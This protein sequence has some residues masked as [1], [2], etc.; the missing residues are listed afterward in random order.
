MEG[1]TEVQENVGAAL[2]LRD[3][4]LESREWEDVARL[5]AKRGATL[6][7]A[8]ER[9]K[10]RVE[11]DP[12]N[13]T[14]HSDGIF[15][16]RQLIWWA[17]AV[18]MRAVGVTNHD[19]IAP[20]I[21]D[22][23]DEASRLGVRFVPGLEYTIHR[24]GG[25]TWRGL[26]VG[27]HFFPPEKF[28][29]FVRSEAGGRFCRRFEEA[30]RLKSDQAWAALKAVNERFMAPRGLAPIKRGELWDNSGRTDPVCASVLTVIIIERIFSQARHDLLEE[31]PNT[32]AVFTYMNRNG[33]VPPLDSPPQTL[34]GVIE[35]REELARHGIRSVLTLNHPEEWLTKCGLVGKD[36]GP[37]LPAIRRLVA[38]LIL[39]DPARAPFSFIELYTP[40]NTD[41]TRALFTDLFN[42]FGDL[43]ERCFPNLAVLYA[44]ASTDSHRVSGFLEGNGQVKGWAPGEDFVFGI[45]MMD[46][47]HPRG[48]LEVPEDYPGADEVL[49]LMERCAT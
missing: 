18:G 48:N 46:D 32:R 23:V 9:L 47:D 45:G 15:T 39:H 25:E 37:D 1:V 41:S 6:D 42:E 43:R 24:L 3:A 16:Y 40:R 30:A 34:D 27:L 22:A 26:E 44:I 10:P 21:G 31:F 8:R 35:I 28:A 12:H 4:I 13:H 19:N 49:A 14:V 7:E 5:L 2:A 11:F 20:Q 29:D 38:L 33:L 17:K 36:G